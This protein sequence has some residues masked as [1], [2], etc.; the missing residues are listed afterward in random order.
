M[1]GLG[2]PRAGA[3]MP[4]WSWRS[5]AEGGGPRVEQQVEGAAAAA[6]EVEGSI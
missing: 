3:M 2:L 4:A 1:P 5:E 6:C